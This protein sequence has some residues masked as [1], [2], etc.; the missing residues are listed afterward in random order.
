MTETIFNIGYLSFGILLTGGACYGL[1]R[2][3]RTFLLDPDRA[4][5]AA[6]QCVTR[7]LTV[8]FCLL[9]CGYMMITGPY[10]SL[11][12]MPGQLVLAIS[13]RFGFLL[14][15]TGVALLIALFVLSNLRKTTR[16]EGNRRESILA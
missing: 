9:M 12:L 2:A 10:I 11:N 6:V 1:F 15:V 13:F 4:N 8:A 5:F 3:S 14:V 7:L 16:R